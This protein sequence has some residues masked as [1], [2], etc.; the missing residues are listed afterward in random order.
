M[1]NDMEEKANLISMYMREML[2]QRFRQSCQAKSNRLNLHRENYKNR[3]KVNKKKQC[4]EQ[5]QYN[6]FD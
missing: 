6:E 4:N 2:L 3:L 5:S 1:K